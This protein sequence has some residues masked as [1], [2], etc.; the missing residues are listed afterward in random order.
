[1]GKALGQLFM[2]EEVKKLSEM[3]EI[4]LGNC[5]FGMVL[6]VMA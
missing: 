3:V 2:N 4:G 5:S 1:M 6:G